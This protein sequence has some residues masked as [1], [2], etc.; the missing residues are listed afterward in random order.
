M[1]YY[2]TVWLWVKAYALL[3]HSLVVGKGICLIISVWLWVKAYALLYLSG[4]V[5]IGLILVGRG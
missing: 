4:V 5:G 3:Y 1:P 2:I